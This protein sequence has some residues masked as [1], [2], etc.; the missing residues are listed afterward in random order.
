M[1]H[2][3]TTAPT[4]IN[5]Q[6]RGKMMITDAKVTICCDECYCEEDIFLAY[7]YT[8]YGGGGGHWEDSD[9][10]VNKFVKKNG[11]TQNEE[12]EHFCKDCSNPSQP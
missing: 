3:P 6:Q 12:E 11:W 2:I 8:T 4:Q 1:Q 9:H 5:Q 7:A 10:L